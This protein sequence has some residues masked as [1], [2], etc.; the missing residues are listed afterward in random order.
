[1]T[2]NIPSANNSLNSYGT[3]LQKKKYN[4]L[5]P[6]AVV[7]EPIN[8]QSSKQLYGKVNRHSLAVVP[9]E[10]FLKQAS[11]QNVFALNFVV[12]A[13]NAMRSFIKQG[14]FSG[15]LNQ[16]SNYT[17]LEVKN[18]WE[19]PKKLYHEYLELVYKVF[20]EKFILKN[21]IK[22]EIINFNSFLKV[23][24]E[25]LQVFVEKYPFTFSAFVLS[26][27]CSNNTSGL[28]VEI[29]TETFDDDKLKFMKYINDKNFDVICN[30]AEQHGFFIDKNAPWRFIANV[31][32]SRMKKYMERYSFSLENVFKKAYLDVS[33]LELS[34]LKV[35]VLQF[36]NSLVQ[37]NLL[38]ASKVNENEVDNKLWL[39]LFL[40]IKMSETHLNISQEKFE[41]EFLKLVEFN[42]Q[43]TL[44]DVLF[45]IGKK[46]SYNNVVFADELQ[47]ADFTVDKSTKTKLKFF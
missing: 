46:Y 32:S 9:N 36:Y 17:K 23:F 38:T 6:K 44:E 41:R 11:E 39:R 4:E 29:T 15:R 37:N 2:N 20:S 25:F 30:I 26:N 47:L 45:F 3:F 1:M 40:L 18:A 14:L 8:I 35:Y 12:D 21:N 33:V 28:V 13:F 22:S 10:V 5:Y 43:N 27:L 19:N 34:Y 7:P 16:T 42:K 24:I 31:G